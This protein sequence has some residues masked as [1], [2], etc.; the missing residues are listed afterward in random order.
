MFL[1][2]RRTFLKQVPIITS[3]LVAG[4]TACSHRHRLSLSPPAIKIGLISPLTGAWATWAKAHLAGA[5]LA[6]D[7]INGAGGVLGRV[8]DPIIIDSKTQP[9]LV[10]KE[11]Y[12]LI[13]QDRVAFIAGTFSSAERNAA[14]PVITRENKILL[15]PTWYEGQN[16]K[17][18]PGVCNPNIFM[19]GPEPNQQILPHVE[20]ML[21][22]FGSKFFLLG[23]NYAWGYIVTQVMAEYLHQIGGE[24]VGNLTV[25]LGTKNFDSLLEQIKVSKANVIF[26][27][28]AGDTFA[29]RQEFYKSGLKKHFIFWSVDDEE[30]ATMNLGAKV[31][32]N[33]YSSFDYFMSINTANNRGFLQR[34]R[35]KFGQQVLINTVGVA[36]YNAIHMVAKAMETIGDV[37]NDAIIHG[38]KGMIFDLAPQGTVQMRSQ[39]NQILVPTYLMKVR[40]GWTNADDMFQYV[41]SFSSVSPKLPLCKSHLTYGS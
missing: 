9:K 4:A 14:A 3:S 17:Y 21:K 40:E 29:F 8:L 27:A 2:S 10:A 5:L 41:Q 39:D 13:H 25:P 19:F 24:V 36:M 33:D 35:A 11:T 34:F 22:T 16:F 7:E 18:F 28:L 1:V 30:L 32:A 6:I 31:T 20:Y 23:A 12:R 26:S 37:S 15:Y 38:L